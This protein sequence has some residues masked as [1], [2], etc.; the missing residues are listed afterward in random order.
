MRKEIAVGIMALSVVTMIAGSGIANANTSSGRSQTEHLRIMST[1]AVSR[2]LS[3][4]ATGAFTSGGRDI[5]AAKTDTIVFPRGRFKFRHLEK[6]FK[7][8]FDP[9]TCLNR[10]TERGTFTISHGTGKYAGIHGSGK[11]VTSIVAVTAMNRAGECMH[12]QAPATFQQ[13]TTAIGTVRRE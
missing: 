9:S 7:A 4:I 6:S 10:E 3:V 13:I 12:V 2:R 5:P 1:K 11:F 8:N